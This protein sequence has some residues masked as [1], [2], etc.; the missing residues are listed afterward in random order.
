MNDGMERKENEQGFRED[1]T[2]ISSW[3]ELES[4]KKKIRITGSSVNTYVA[5]LRDHI[6]APLP[7]P[8]VRNRSPRTHNN[9]YCQ[10]KGFYSGKKK[11]ASFEVYLAQGVFRIA[12]SAGGRN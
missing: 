1:T 12:T 10:K 8:N 6:I 2:L 9:S 5:L 4:N 7:P 11:S 3:T